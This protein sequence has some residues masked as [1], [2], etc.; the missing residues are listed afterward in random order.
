MCRLMW[1]QQAMRLYLSADGATQHPAISEQNQNT[2]EW[3]VETRVKSAD[4]IPA[5]HPVWSSSVISFIDR[6]FIDCVA[7]AKSMIGTTRNDASFDLQS[8]SDTI[9]IP[10][11][12][13]TRF[14]VLRG[15]GYQHLVFVDYLQASGG[16]FITVSFV[17]FLVFTSLFIVYTFQYFHIQRSVMT[18]VWDTLLK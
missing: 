15:I 13:S 12:W 7:L 2:V 9:C 11:L 3:P 16:C 17:S 6:Y 8:S 4:G 1:I 10:Q 5:S 18:D 14:D